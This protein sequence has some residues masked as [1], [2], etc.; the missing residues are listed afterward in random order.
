M[1]S[2]MREV[3]MN[4]LWPFTVFVVHCR[5]PVCG[6]LPSTYQVTLFLSSISVLIRKRAG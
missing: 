3:N 4:P 1:L 6:I 5:L 2:P